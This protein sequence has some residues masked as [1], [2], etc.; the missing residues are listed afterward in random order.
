M[1]IYH[2]IKASLRYFLC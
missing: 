2:T 1:P